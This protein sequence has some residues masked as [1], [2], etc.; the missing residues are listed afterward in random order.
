MHYRQIRI[1][2]I[3]KF[4]FPT[5]ASIETLIIKLTC[6]NIEHKCEEVPTTI[7]Y[8]IVYKV[9]TQDRVKTIVLTYV[10]YL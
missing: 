7:Q 2:P 9:S 5:S 8:S 1:Q 6:Q 3:L 10:S 4:I